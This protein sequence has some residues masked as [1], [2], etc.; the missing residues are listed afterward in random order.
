MVLNRATMAALVL[1]VA[2]V[3]ACTTVRRVQPAAYFAGNSPEVVWVTYANNTV[4]SVVQPE[5]AGDTLRGMRQGTQQPVAIPLGEIQSVQA[6][7]PSAKRT[8]ILVSALGVAFASSVYFMWISKAGNGDN[9]S[10]CL[11]E[12]AMENPEDHPECF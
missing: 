10:D 1:G 7:M 6:R 2:G 12:H 8:I 4:V 11:G 3:A 5:M 9:R